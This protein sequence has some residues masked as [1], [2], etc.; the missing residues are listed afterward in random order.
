MT[1]YEADDVLRQYAATLH[2]E[3][4]GVIRD[5]ADLPYPKEVIRA[6]LK[7]AIEV[8]K[9]DKCARMAQE[10]LRRSSR[11]SAAYHARARGSRGVREGTVERSLRA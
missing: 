2:K 1:T 10:R 5:A 4:Q 7:H 9:D 6:V 3:G 11:L 8:S